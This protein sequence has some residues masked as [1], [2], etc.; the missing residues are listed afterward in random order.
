MGVGRWRDGLRDSWRVS[1][2]V[3]S[4]GR[5]PAG[6]GAGR[7]GRAES[8]GE[9]QGA[10]SSGGVRSLRSAGKSRSAGRSRKTSI[11]APLWRCWRQGERR[12][13]VCCSSGRCVS[14]W[15]RTVGC[16]CSPRCVYVPKARKLQ[17]LQEVHDVPHA[18]V[19]RQ[20]S[21]GDCTLIFLANDAFRRAAICAVV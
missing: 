17:L 8:L 1:W 6:Q 10:G 7:G 5:V 19:G 18:C 9:S 14:S 13:A 15:W 21:F 4:A 16:C 20:V 2:A 12:E 3:R 11:S